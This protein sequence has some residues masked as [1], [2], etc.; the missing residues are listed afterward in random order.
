MSFID[1]FSEGVFTSTLSDPLL[2][3]DSALSNSPTAVVQGEWGELTYYVFS[4]FKTGSGDAPDLAYKLQIS[5]NFSTWVD[6]PGASFIYGP[7]GGDGGLAGQ[8][9]GGN[10]GARVANARLPI[11]RIESANS[12]GS[13]RRQASRW[14]VSSSGGSATFKVQRGVTSWSFH[15]GSYPENHFAF[16]NMPGKPGRL[17]LN[18]A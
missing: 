7:G 17:K 15:K 8:V 9:I 10:Y 12:L 16:D 11:V 2:D 4:F 18:F 3:T 6:V 13:N 5:N 1:P 14:V